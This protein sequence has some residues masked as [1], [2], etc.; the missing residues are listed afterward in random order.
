MTDPRAHRNELLTHHLNTFLSDLEPAALQQ[1]RDRLTWVEI[2][3]GERLMTQ[4]DPG[5]SLY[6]TIS[7]RLRVYVTDEHGITRRVQELG[8]GEVI[9]EMS[10]YT[11]KPRSATV[12][13]LR[14]SVLVRLDQTHFEELLA[15][16]L[17]LSLTLPRKIIERLQQPQHRRTEPR[18]V[19]LTLIP[20]SASVDVVDFAERFRQPLSSLGRVYVLTAEQ[21]DA[22]IDS[23]GLARDEGGDGYRQHRL[24]LH[25]DALEAQYDYVLLVADPTPNAWTRFCC[26]HSDEHLLLADA[27]DPIQLHP[28]ETDILENTPPGLDVAQRLVLLHAEDAVSP[29]HTADWLNR[30][31]VTDHLHVRPQRDRD[32]ARLARIEN[33][34]AVG[35]VLAGG[36][37]RGLAH[38]GVMQAL[39]EAG[40]DVDVVGGT[41]IGAIMAAVI[42]TDK[43]VAHMQDACRKA[44]SKSPTGDYNWLP[45]ISLIRGR[46]LRTLIDESFRELMGHPGQLED[47]W[48]PFYCI[49]TNYSHAREDVLRRGDL[50]RA[51]RATCAIPG[52]LPPILKDG[53]LLCDG[54]TLNN[55]PVN[56]MRSVQ[57]VG[58]VIGVD[59]GTRTAQ[60]LSFDEIPGTWALLF[61]RLRSKNKR[62]YKLPSLATYLVS[63]SFIYSF[64]QRDT[65]KSLTDMYFNPPLKRIG[66]LDWGRM[67]DIFKSGYDYARKQLQ[68]EQSG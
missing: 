46:R 17:H 34:T 52:A 7:G 14:D 48:L 49:A 13:A 33:R 6:L 18:P 1:V 9:G 8:R 4:G 20:I 54:A 57:G 30:R 60:P 24:A 12:V 45:L 39:N 68:S 23:A 27:N 11:G 66:L 51:L 40:I 15:N 37:A 29:R 58:T 38:M 67:E 2:K 36:G 59:L 3:S 61:D 5:D 53:D 25:L 56:V 62:R 44:F 35:L 55:F 16:S 41:S 32:L 31:P 19:T 63:V 10:L 28:T 43:P 47:L 21:A 22:D 50:T 42:A 64:S 65:D 26:S